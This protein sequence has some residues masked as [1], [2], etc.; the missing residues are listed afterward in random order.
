METFSTLLAL[1]AGNS[2]VTGEFPA[3]MPVTPSLDVWCYLLIC[4]WTNGWVNNRDAGDLR[5]YRAHYDVRVMWGMLRHW[6]LCVYSPKR[7]HSLRW[8]HN[9]TIAS[10]ITSLTIVYSTVYPDADQRKHQSSASL[11]FVRGI[12]R[13]PVNSPHKRP[14]TRKMFPFD[15]AIMLQYQMEPIW[16]TVCRS[17]INYFRNRSHGEHVILRSIDMLIEMKHGLLNKFKS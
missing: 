5:R 8:R 11:A 7:A 6:T 1:C 13:G 3:Q 10:Q 15:D 4:I 16:Q 9:G 14:V 12:H 2:P 17:G